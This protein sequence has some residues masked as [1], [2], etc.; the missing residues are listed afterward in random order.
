MI[1]EIGGSFFGP[2]QIEGARPTRGDVVVSMFIGLIHFND[3][4]CFQ[5]FLS[6]V[7]VGDDWCLSLS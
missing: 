2:W 4:W 6:F 1:S 5:T 3:R 7:E